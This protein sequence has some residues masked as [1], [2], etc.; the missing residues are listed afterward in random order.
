[1]QVEYG[2]THFILGEAPK[3][4]PRNAIKDP[5]SNG[6]SNIL[7]ITDEEDSITFFC[8]HSLKHWSLSADD[9]EV[10][11]FIPQGDYDITRICRQVEINLLLRNKLNLP[12][13]MP[14][15]RTVL[16]L[17]G[18]QNLP[19]LP[20][21]TEPEIVRKAAPVRDRKKVPT[22]DNLLT[23]E[24]LVTRLEID[25][26]HVRKYL[27]KTGIE[28]PAWGWKGDEQWMNAAYTKIKAIIE[29]EGR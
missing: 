13:G 8:P 19:E 14:Y 3:G 1:M 29:E 26:K 25:A 2:R 7:K 4:H 15:T 5:T 11:G 17:L 22:P 24:H 16:E 18:S 20:V 9:Y 6:W 28:K 23:I 27:R 10:E 21:K 12:N